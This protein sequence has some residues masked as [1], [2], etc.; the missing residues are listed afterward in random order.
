MLAYPDKNQIRGGDRDVLDV[1]PSL[2]VGVHVLD[3]TR[4]GDGTSVLG[5]LE[6][7][8]SLDGGVSLEDS[9]GLRVEASRSEDQGGATR[10]MNGRGCSEVGD[11]RRL[12][13]DK[14]SVSVDHLASVH[15][16]TVTVKGMEDAQVIV[17]SLAETSQV[18]HRP[19]ESNHRPATLTLTIFSVSDE[20]L[21]GFGEV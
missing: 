9:D 11:L 3:L 20:V 5:L 10:W 16:I 8:H 1:E 4:D 6:R 13:N 17:T 18:R 7:D 19:P 15:T 14:M 21:V 12:D 2:G